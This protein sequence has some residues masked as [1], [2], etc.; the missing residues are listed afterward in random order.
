M[1]LSFVRGFTSTTAACKVGCAM[2]KPVHHRI[3]IDK[4]ALSPRFPEL[5]LKPSDIR[6]P[7]YRPYLTEE[8]RVKDH[9][10]NTLASDMLL[11]GYRH[12][13][14]PLEGN[15]RRKWPMDSQ[16]QLNRPLRKPRG[17]VVPSP[18]IV[19]RNWRNIPRFETITVHC[20]VKDAKTKPELAIAAS[21]QLQQMTGVK[22]KVVY[23]KTN[24]PT[25]SL[26]PGMRMGAKAVLAGSDAS[27]FLTTLTEFVLP[28]IREFTGVSNRSGDRYG[29]ISFGL[30]PEDIKLFPEIENSQDAWP[31]TF[32]VD[33]TLH[34]SAQ[35]DAEA[36]I[37]LSGLGI[38]FTG[39]ER[40]PKTLLEDTA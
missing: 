21:L 11:I 33:I 20:W 22:P 17:Q 23:S 31:K 16:Y 34:T 12:E 5:K 7:H 13:Q 1:S 6:S 19:P 27:Q 15:K 8:D 4:Q 3:K 37:L 10:F 36:R 25:W 35:T 24:V 38:P 18:T 40:V 26:R 9:Y 30:E 28:R 2:V 39:S 32:G 29:N 14:V